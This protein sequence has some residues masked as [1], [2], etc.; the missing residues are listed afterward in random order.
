MDFGI[1]E[2]HGGICNLRF[3]DT[4]PT[5]EDVGKTTTAHNLAMGLVMKGFKVLEIDL[6]AQCNASMFNGWLTTDNVGKRTIN[7]ALKNTSAMPVYKSEK[8]LYYTP[9]SPDMV[10]IDPYLRS[11]MASCLVLKSIFDLP[12]ERNFEN[13]DITMIDDFDFVIIDCP[14]SLQPITLNAMCVATGLI[15]PVQL[16]PL[17]VVGLGNIIAKFKEVQRTF[18]NK[19]AIRGLLLVMN[20]ARPR[21]R[22][23]YVKNIKEVF[24]NL[25]YNTVIARNIK[26]EEAQDNGG[27][28]YSYAPDSIGAKDYLSFVDEFLSKI[29]LN[30]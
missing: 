7:D 15:I 4:N 24:T 9:S 26:I 16:S 29:T 22:K 3:D 20:D 23:A 27:D 10:N 13:E 6:D 1:A 12:I 14:P 25:V 2:S 19:L 5:K 21:L 17:A 11:T 28:V 18:N 30:K 8:G